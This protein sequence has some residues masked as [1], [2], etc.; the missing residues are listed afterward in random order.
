MNY[1]A[2]ISNWHFPG[3]KLA[4]CMC[5]LPCLQAASRAYW[6]AACPPGSA[7]TVGTCRLLCSL[8]H[9]LLY[10]V[11]MHS[12]KRGTY[13]RSAASSGP[14]WAGFILRQFVWICFG[15]RC[16]DP[17]IHSSATA[18]LLL[19]ILWLLDIV[20][21]HINLWVS[22]RFSLSFPVLH[23][24]TFLYFLLNA[25]ARF[26]LSAGILRRKT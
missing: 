13:T 3:T 11:L 23:R 15:D 1:T 7:S 16:T 8:Q 4:I 21:P 9:T 14:S 12:M 25:P 10:W 22:P 18:R 17:Q 6:R 26:I 5:G 2:L 19:G 24:Q 20:T